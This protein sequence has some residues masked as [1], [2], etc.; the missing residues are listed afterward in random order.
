MGCIEG[1]TKRCQ[2][3]EDDDE[4]DEEIVTSFFWVVSRVWGETVNDREGSNRKSHNSN[5]KTDAMVIDGDGARRNSI[6]AWSDRWGVLRVLCVYVV[7]VVA[8]L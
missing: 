5:S 8:K 7:V 4:E 1:G 3:G 2:V 6:V